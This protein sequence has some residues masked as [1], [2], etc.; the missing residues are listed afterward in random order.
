MAKVI[1]IPNVGVEGYQLF[2]LCPACGEKHSCNETWQFNGDM[3][4]PTIDPSL[5]V[6]WNEGDKEL[7]CHSVII[8]GVIHFQNDCTHEFKGQ[9][10]KL[11][12][13]G[14]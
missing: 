1:K 14:L 11:S 10:L 2:F 13:I 8:K 12:E 7:M 4:E 9:S 3:E 6:R 5:R